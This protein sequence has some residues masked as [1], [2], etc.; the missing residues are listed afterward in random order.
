MIRSFACKETKEIWE[1]RGS[2]KFPGSI[3]ERALNKLRLIDAPSSVADLRIPPGN[4]LEK[5]NDNRYGEFSIRINDQWRIC[6]M[7]QNSHA[8]QVQIVDYH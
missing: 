4:R 1:G 5:L 6:F 2:G 7:W 3:Q 8:E